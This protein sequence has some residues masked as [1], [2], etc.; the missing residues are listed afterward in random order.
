[1]LYTKFR[2]PLVH[3][4]AIDKP[5][6]AYPS[7]F[8]QPAVG[9]WG[10]VRLHD[11]E[12][13]DAMPAW[14]DDWPTLSVQDYNGGKRLKLSCAALYWAVKNMVNTLAADTAIVTAAAAFHRTTATT[15]MTA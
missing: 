15:V 9:K 14:D 7:T 4:L 5:T 13:I 1:V 3:E 6:R 10:A 8:H 2:N 11:I 12:A